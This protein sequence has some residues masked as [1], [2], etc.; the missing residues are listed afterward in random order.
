[1]G[2]GLTYWLFQ[3]E[4]WL[5]IGVLLVI[6]D[7][8]VGLQFFVLAFG[9]ASILIGALLFGQKANLFGEI[10]L[11]STWRDFGYWFAA[12]SILSFGIVKLVFQRTTKDEKDINQY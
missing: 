8:Y 11:F 2:T 5:I 10:L 7:I 4:T 3:T 9:V 12:L 6:L 1:M